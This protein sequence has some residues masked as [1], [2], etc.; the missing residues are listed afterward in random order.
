MI[1]GREFVQVDFDL[2]LVVCEGGNLLFEQSNIVSV[3]RTGEVFTV[4]TRSS[5]AY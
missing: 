5:T 2:S 4:T 3:I 1:L